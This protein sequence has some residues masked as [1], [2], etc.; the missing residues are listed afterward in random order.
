MSRKIGV[1]INIDVSK[2]DKNRF[3]KGEKGN[4]C[5]LT[6]FIDPDNPSEW[7][8]HG[9]VT[10]SKKK[11]EAKDVQLPI[12]GNAKVFWQDQSAPQAPSMPTAQTAPPV[13][14]G[15][16]DNIDESDIPF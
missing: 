8:T 9:I 1:N 4:Y 2:L 11:D 6:V 5:D 10:Q 15:Q 12:L 13:D 3:H 16:S 14:Y 7:G